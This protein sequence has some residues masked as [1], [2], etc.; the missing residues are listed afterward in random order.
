VGGG[1]F[2]RGAQRVTGERFDEVQTA[3]GE[4]GKAV[5]DGQRGDMVGMHCDDDRSRR[6]GAIGKPGTQRLGPTL[7]VVVE[8]E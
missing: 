7:T 8:G 6:R 5:V 1:T 2:D 4:A 3:F